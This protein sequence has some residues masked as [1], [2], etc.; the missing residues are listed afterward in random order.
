MSKAHPVLRNQRAERVKHVARH[1]GIG[2]LI[3]SQA[4]RRVLHVEHNH[5]FALA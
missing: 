1:V 5:T 2:I 3:N 4:S